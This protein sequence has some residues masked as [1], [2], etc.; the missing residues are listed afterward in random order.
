LSSGTATVADADALKDWCSRSPA[1][2][3]AFVEANA[4]WDRLGP[5]SLGSRGSAGIGKR[6]LPGAMLNRRVVLTGAIAAS[7]AGL[8]VV[9]PPLDLWP[10]L[11]EMAAD[12]RTGVGERRQVDLLGG[13]LDMNTRTSLAIK[14]GEGRSAVELIAGEVVV[15]AHSGPFE[16]VAAEGRIT[17]HAAS[18]NIRL[19]GGKACVTCLDGE[20]SVAYQT[21][22][23]PLSRG[24]RVIYGDDALTEAVVVDPAMASAWS[25]GMLIF[26]NE[27][28][29]QVIAEI[30]RYRHGKVVLMDRKLATRRIEASFRLDRV[31][32]VISL[33]REVY[34]AQVTH[35]P[36]GIVVLS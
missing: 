7:V 23:L 2:A 16:L 33:V 30:N 3:A 21:R 31:D 26:H 5:A 28:L 34:G 9:R 22:H 18:F 27:P 4:L 6:S 10:S 24:H 1:H 17:A 36:G 20:V 19:D 12:Y 25:R 13:T 35:L 32:D 15:A 14:S 8:F 11:S 29:A